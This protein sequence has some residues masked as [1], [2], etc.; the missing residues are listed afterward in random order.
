[1]RRYPAGRAWPSRAHLAR[2]VARSTRVHSRRPIAAAISLDPAIFRR[3]SERQRSARP[4]PYA[5]QRAPTAPGELRA[6]PC[7]RSVCLEPASMPPPSEDGADGDARFWDGQ[8]PGRNG[9]T[10]RAVPTDVV[11]IGV[12][13]TW[14]TS[15][16][17]GPGSVPSARRSAARNTRPRPTHRSGFRR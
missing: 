12:N 17:P 11:A 8:P 16:S 2:R 10:S 15:R 3:L 4:G 6:T 13:R 14:P 5:A 9:T 7:Q 1:M